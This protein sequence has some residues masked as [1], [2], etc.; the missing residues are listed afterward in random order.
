MKEFLT[1][2]PRMFLMGM[3]LGFLWL[4]F[5][6]CDDRDINNS[7][8][9]YRKPPAHVCPVT[10]TFVVYITESCDPCPDCE[11]C[12]GPPHGHGHGD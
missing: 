11:P 10:D 4:A 6:G 2:K 9:T 7:N 3:A 5:Q 1:S 8:N 12:D